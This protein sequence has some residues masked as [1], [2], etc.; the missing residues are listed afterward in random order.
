ML[1]GAKDKGFPAADA[2]SV[3]V[4]AGNDLCPSHAAAVAGWTPAPQLANPSPTSPSPTNPTPTLA[5][6]FSQLAGGGTCDSNGKYTPPVA[7]PDAN[8]ALN[9]IGTR[10]PLRPVPVG[11]LEAG[12]SRGPIP[13]IDLLGGSNLIAT[14]IPNGIQMRVANGGYQSLSAPVSAWWQNIRIDADVRPVQVPPGDQVGISCLAV[15]RSTKYAFLVGPGGTWSIESSH[16]TGAA[17][18]VVDAGVSP[19]IKDAPSNHLSVA[20]VG[21]R[22]GGTDVTYAV[23]GVEIAHDRAPDVANGWIPALTM[24]SCAGPSAADFLG[25]TEYAVPA[26]TG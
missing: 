25:M 14:A 19:A 6:C 21:A 24:C 23:N 12:S 1:A 26:P 4:H 13:W 7:R 18:D 10:L 20:C 11:V 8:G 22:G 3:I 17:P 15:D 5:P 2:V 16:N 9:V